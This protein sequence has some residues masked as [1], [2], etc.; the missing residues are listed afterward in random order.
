MSLQ[1]IALGQTVRRLGGQPELR[2][3]VRDQAGAEV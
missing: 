2:L 3:R 1:V